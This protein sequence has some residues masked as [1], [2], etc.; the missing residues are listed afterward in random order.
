MHRKLTTDLWIRFSVVLDGHHCW[1]LSNDYNL[2]RDN[3]VM[4][5]YMITVVV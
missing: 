2:P 4:T 1:G 3:Q 5:M